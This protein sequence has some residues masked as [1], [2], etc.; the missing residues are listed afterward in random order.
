MKKYDVIIIGS[1]IGGLICGAYLA[2][3]GKKVLVLEKNK[4]P[5]GYCTSF[6][7]RGF[8]IDSTIHA[9]QSCQEGSVLFRIFNELKVF[10]KLRLVR[11]NPTD[12]IFSNKGIIH[13]DNDINVTINNFKAIFKNESRGIDNFFKILTNSNFSSIYFKFRDKSFKELLDLCFKN[14]EIKAI[15]DIFLGNIGSFSTQT[16]SITAI[17]LLRQFI[18]YGGYYPSG[19]MQRIPD[20][21]VEI[22]RHFDGRIIF[23]KKVQKIIL[24]ENVAVGVEV[25]DGGIFN[26]ECIVSNSDL[27]YT[28]T[29]LLDLNNSF[30]EFYTK[31]KQYTPSYSIFIHYL[32]LKKSLKNVLNTGSGIWFVPN[33]K[34]L[35][36]YDIDNL[37][38]R[39]NIGMFCSISSKLDESLMPDDHDIV[40][41]MVSAKYKDENYW[42]INSKSIEKCLVNKLREVVPSIDQMIICSGRTTAKT[43]QNYTINSQGAVCGWMNTVYQVNNP[44]V[45]YMPRIKNLYFT[46][47]W[48]SNLYGNGGIAM[49]AES[50]YNCAKKVIRSHT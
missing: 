35:E 50:G 11:S 18:L 29:R 36:D 4:E 32:L 22:I 27:K 25:R 16:S 2:K 34:C 31:L 10:D 47:H 41:L 7:R 8:L 5:G 39:H 12:T 37:H 45:N 28:F 9:I 1:G 24:K 20:Q 48:I 14:D 38:R 30:P 15:F 26:A 33:E 23:Q 46:G 17:A 49:A 3:N 13:I 6:Y 19:G 43:M 42:R 21:L 40:R 44:I